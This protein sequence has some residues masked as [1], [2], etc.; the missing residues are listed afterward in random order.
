MDINKIP[1]CD[2]NEKKVKVTNFHHSSDDIGEKDMFFAIKGEKVDGHNYLGEVAKK[3]AGAAVVSKDYKGKD[4]GMTLFR[5]S[6]VL[7]SLQ[8]LAKRKMEESKG[9]VVAIT[10]SIGKTIT[11]EFIASL[12]A[13]KFNVYK[14]PSNKNSQVTMPLNVLNN[15]DEVEFFVLEMGM[16]FNGELTKL[17]NI[18]PPFMAV[19]TKIAMTHSENFKDGLKGIAKA[20]MEIFGSKDTCHKIF[21]FEMYQLIDELMGKSFSCHNDKSDFFLSPL[22]GSYIVREK[23]RKLWR[24]FPT[25]TADHI[26]ENLMVA[27][28]SVRTL[29]MS[30]DDINKVVPTLTLPKLRFEVIDKNGV[31]YVKDCY[32]AC[33]ESMIAA[34]KNMPRKS[35]GKS[36]AVLGAM[37][38]LGEFSYQAHRDVI[39]FAV[40]YC[41]TIILL[42]KEWDMVDDII[43]SSNKKIIV[44]NDKIN[45]VDSL[46]KVITTGDVVLVKGANCYKLEDIFSLM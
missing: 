32:N 8:G 40:L 24:C 13:S 21:P 30:V 41:D 25:F 12:L 38:E 44:A 10:G 11:K 14:S 37:K 3:G 16:S 15:K 1:L 6:N 28:A 45:V 23:R 46:R 5:S 34:I 19:I 35:N 26:I 20:K 33:C 18:A 22:N 7:A 17:I 31:T 4:Y 36:I 42:G 43:N 39:N 27:I 2:N 29:G 9:K